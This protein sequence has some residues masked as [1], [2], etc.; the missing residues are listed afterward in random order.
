MKELNIQ[1]TFLGIFSDLADQ[2]S[3]RLP[4]KIGPLVVVFAK[5]TPV[6]EIFVP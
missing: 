1:D 5:G 3:W 4:K 2:K 6:F